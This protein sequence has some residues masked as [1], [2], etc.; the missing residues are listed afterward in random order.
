MGYILFSRKR[1][2]K[3]SKVAS[4]TGEKT[5][6]TKMHRN[7]PPIQNTNPFIEPEP[8]D[9]YREL[10]DATRNTQASAPQSI[11]KTY[12]FPGNIELTPMSKQNFSSTQRYLP[13]GH[14]YTNDSHNPSD[15]SQDHN[16]G[17]SG[18]TPLGKHN[19][20]IESD[21]WHQAATQFIR[22]SSRVSKT[23]LQSDNV[24]R[25][26]QI[27]STSSSSDT[28]NTSKIPRPSFKRSR[29]AVYGEA[30]TENKFINGA[31]VHIDDRMLMSSTMVDEVDFERL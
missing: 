24:K 30:Y 16:L 21:H 25:V 17:Q 22:R 3:S 19:S 26:S 31:D 28:F 18:F 6:H 12:S 20:W 23:S 13:G 15:P 11:Y 7:S 2:R 1:K 27:T 14:C 4:Q 5:I 8:A 10:Q 9:D 29:S